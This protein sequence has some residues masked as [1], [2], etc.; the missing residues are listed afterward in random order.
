MRACLHLH[1]SRLTPRLALAHFMTM[2]VWVRYARCLVCVFAFCMR[3]IMWA[4]NIKLARHTA[5]GKLESSPDRTRALLHAPRCTLRCP[6]KPLRSSTVTTNQR[7]TC[8]TSLCTAASLSRDTVLS[9]TARV[10]Q[11]NDARRAGPCPCTPCSSSLHNASTHNVAS[12]SSPPSSVPR[13]EHGCMNRP[14][15][16]QDTSIYKTA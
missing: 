14:D 12:P 4:S 5:H 10:W 8:K 16:P 1:H 7:V 15:C 3:F 2:N 13:T 9:A 6:L 11:R